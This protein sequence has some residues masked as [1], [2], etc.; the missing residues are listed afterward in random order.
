MASS[1]PT[2]WVKARKGC[3]FADVGQGVIIH[4]NIPVALK[5]TARIKQGLNTKIIEKISSELAT[6]MQGE[7]DDKELQDANLITARN[8]Q[9]AA[10]L[11]AKTD[12][13]EDGLP[14]GNGEDANEAQARFNGY[15]VKQLLNLV[16]VVNP[17]QVAT[18]KQEKKPVIVQWLLD[19]NGANV[20]IDYCGIPTSA[21]HVYLL[22]LDAA[23]L[24]STAGD[25][26]GY[27]LGASRTADGAALDA[28]ITAWNTDDS[29][30]MSVPSRCALVEKMIQLGW[31]D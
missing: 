30:N 20:V 10:F 15:S 22:G 7:I 23:I 9:K 24:A 18:L 16:N 17:S 8:E 11:A 3:S 1:N 25:Y 29:A 13:D 4:G 31:T 26:V 6:K 27:L 21:D 2:I 5:E 14:D 28:L 19:N 12:S